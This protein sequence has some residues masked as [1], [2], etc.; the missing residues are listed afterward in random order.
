MTLTFLFLFD[1]HDVFADIAGGDE[2]GGSG[3]R[4]GRDDGPRREESAAAPRADRGLAGQR[5][6]AACGRVDGSG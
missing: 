6:G 3:R 4:R 1:V 5:D 2:G